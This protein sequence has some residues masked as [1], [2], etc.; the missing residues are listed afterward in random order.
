MRFEAA[1]GSQG[2]VCVARPR[3]PDLLAPEALE[4]LCPGRLG[5]RTGPATCTE[6]GARATPG[7]L[8]FNKS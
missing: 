6:E 7:V 8:L 4:G 1:W 2:A 3:V 5:G